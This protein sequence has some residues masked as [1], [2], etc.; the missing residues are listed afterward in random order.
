MKRNPLLRSTLKVFVCLL[1]AGF[2]SNDRAVMAQGNATEGSLLA[3]DAKGQMA[4]PCPLK[5][6]DVKTEISGFL[7]R[8]TVTQHFENPFSDKI[9][10]VYTFPLPQAAAVDDMTIVVGDRTVKGKSCAAKTRKPPMTPPEQRARSPVCCI[11]KDQTSS[12]N[13]SPI[14][15]RASR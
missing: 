8:V 5:H 10:A 2:I 14:F 15:F 4:G 12:R 9:E 1:F 3:V 11:S 6:T 7:A 13:Q